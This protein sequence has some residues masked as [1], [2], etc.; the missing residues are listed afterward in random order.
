MPSP[1]TLRRSLQ[2]CRLHVV[3][4]AAMT[5]SG[6]VPWSHV[7]MVDFLTEKEITCPICMDAPEFT[8]ITQCGHIYCLMCLVRFRQALGSK[9][10][11]C[12]EFILSN[13]IRLCRVQLTPSVHAGA[14]ITF[15]LVAANTANSV[16][17]PAGLPP[18]TSSPLPTQA[19]P[20]WWLSPTVKTSPVEL[21]RHVSRELAE[22]ERRL[23]TEL[24]LDDHEAT[25]IIIAHEELL[26]HSR[27]LPKVSS[28]TQSDYQPYL[29]ISEELI[30]A[31]VAES[32]GPFAA[33]ERKTYFYQ[34]AAGSAVFL[35]P[36]WSRALLT[37]FAE[38]DWARAHFM[39]RCLDLIITKADSVSVDEASTRRYR[40]LAH[41]SK[42][43]SAL[44]CDVEVEGL[45]SNTT[46]SLLAKAL[47]RREREKAERRVQDE[48]DEERRRQYEMKAAKDT[49]ERFNLVREVQL[50]PK[51]E[52]F[53]ALPRSLSSRSPAM[54]V[55][56]TESLTGQ[57]S[58]RHTSSPSLTFAQI[59]A[60][61]AS[62][63][64]PEA[65]LFESFLQTESATSPRTTANSGKKKKTVFRLAG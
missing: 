23:A 29:A 55:S 50:I 57:S 64:P 65:G 26:K 27:T 12:S 6:T 39:P 62:D 24:Y 61:P 58:P 38:Q 49:L 45:I 9:C 25:T 10:A 22:L 60:R 4:D 52:D 34:C 51:P 53:V 30:A 54:A 32:S 59:A 48:R 31:T 63:L 56:S 33:D 21:A 5:G 35:D 3:S 47:E 41:L 11:I 8:R 15:V 18:L 28:S 14:L 19:T 1:K 17:L 40:C 44:V 20:G 42:G 2:N 46:R 43:Q 37:E 16:V 7:V 36:L 13:E